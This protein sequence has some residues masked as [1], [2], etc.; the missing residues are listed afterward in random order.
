[1]AAHIDVLPTL[2]DLCNF[3]LPQ[4]RK[5]DGKSLWPLLM[6]EK[7]KQPERPFFSYWT[8]RYPEKY[9]NISMQKGNYK[10]VGHTDYSTNPEAIELF[11]H[12]SDPYEQENIVAGNIEIAKR[13]MEELETHYV[14]LIASENIINPPRIHLGSKHENPVTLNRNDAGGERGIWDQ[15]EVYG[16]WAVQINEGTYNIRFKFIE[17][18]E[19]KGKMYLETGA[20]INQFEND[21][22]SIDMLEMKNVS[23]PNMSA[24]LIPFYMSKSKRIFPFWVEMD[25]I[26]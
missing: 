20:I 7:E 11:D 25:R 2:A 6:G 23:L 16:K 26:D 15:E 8:R 22:I 4:D 10:L 1:M 13:L 19:E 9:H 3:P 17:P 5:I 18:L 24:D 21:Q 12:E 14:E